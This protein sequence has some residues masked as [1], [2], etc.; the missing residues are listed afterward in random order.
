MQFFG[1]RTA[2]MTVVNRSTKIRARDAG[3]SKGRDP[4]FSD[5]WMAGSRASTGCLS[6]RLSG[7]ETFGIAGRSRQIDRAR[8]SP[9]FPWNFRLETCDLQNV[10]MALARIGDSRTTRT[11]FTRLRDLRLRV[12]IRILNDRAIGQSQT[13]GNRNN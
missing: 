13:H 11:I 7:P 6:T 8:R 3:G 5:P 10:S 2:K 9:T 12:R 1:E 4:R